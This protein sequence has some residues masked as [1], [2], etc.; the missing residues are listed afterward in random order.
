MVGT[1]AQ[2]SHAEQASWCACECLK[3]YGTNATSF[4]TYKTG[5]DGG[6]YDGAC[7][8]F[9]GHQI[10][11]NTVVG[12]AEDADCANDAGGCY[13]TYN[14]LEAVVPPS[15]PPPPG[16]SP[17]GLPPGFVAT[18]AASGASAGVG[19][20]EPF[21]ETGYFEVVSDELADGFTRPRTRKPP[22][23]AS[24]STSTTGWGAT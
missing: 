8:C 7:V 6:S 1:N 9:P 23:S 22:R 10:G 21:H 15:P 4:A 16:S 12:G 14:I 5:T 24:R 13:H 20:P 2:P 11:C 18:P 19:L 17:P 3:Q